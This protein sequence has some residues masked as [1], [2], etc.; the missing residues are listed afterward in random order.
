CELEPYRKKI[1]YLLSLELIVK[2]E[3]DQRRE[4]AQKLLNK[5]KQAI[6]EPSHKE[7]VETQMTS[8][9]A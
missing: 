1:E 7:S 3:K 5:Y 9:L 4:N 8:E 6:S 2:M